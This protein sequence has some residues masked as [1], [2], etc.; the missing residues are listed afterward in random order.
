MNG[1]GSADK[2]EKSLEYVFP[3]LEMK[4]PRID[5]LEL[6]KNLSTPRFIKSHLHAKFFKRQLEGTNTCPKFIIVI[7]NPNSVLVSSYH[8]YKSVFQYKGTWDQFFQLAAKDKRLLYG[9]YINHVLSWVKY[10]DHQKVHFL[11]YEDLKSDP[12][13]H[14]QGVAEFLHKP[15][16]KETVDMI[17]HETSFDSMKVR[18]QDQY[19]PNFFREGKVSGWHGY[20]ND[21]QLKYMNKICDSELKPVGITFDC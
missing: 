16:T 1:P 13:L 10:Q 17:V 15:L 9:D 7:R 14:I 11:K 2:R 3:F 6:A 5:G 19:A 20:F 4:S 12:S 18:S 21:G 8:F